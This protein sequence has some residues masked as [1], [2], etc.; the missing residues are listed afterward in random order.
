MDFTYILRKMTSVEGCRQMLLTSH[1]LTNVPEALI[2]EKMT[3]LSR[4]QP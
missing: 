2:K 4:V 1:Q 3:K